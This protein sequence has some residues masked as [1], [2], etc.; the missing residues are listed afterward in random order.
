MLAAALL[1][2]TI[3]LAAGEP[4][5]GA[6]A[7]QA[8]PPNA[9]AGKTVDPAVVQGKAKDDPNQL[10]CHTETPIGS[11]LSVKK[12]MTKGEA[13]M[14]KFEDRQAIEHMQGDTYHH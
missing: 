2:S 3:L 7:S 9:P 4:A 10:V 11:R 6:Q 14:R 8:P 12:C 1:A 5:Q 13:D